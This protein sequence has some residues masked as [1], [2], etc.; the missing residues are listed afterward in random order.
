MGRR[1]KQMW[2]NQFVELYEG[3][4]DLHLKRDATKAT[5]FDNA[6]ITVYNDK[7][8]LNSLPITFG[9]SVRYKTT[10][11][12]RAAYQTN[13]SLLSTKHLFLRR[14]SYLF[15]RHTL[16]LKDILSPQKIKYVFS[17]FYFTLLILI[18][19]SESTQIDYSNHF[20]IG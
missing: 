19:L 13:G 17:I 5:K 1:R 15:S 3:D 20:F 9:Y 12:R 8:E 7:K 11:C 2:S 6:L 18:P 10:I 16:S 14:S 4:V